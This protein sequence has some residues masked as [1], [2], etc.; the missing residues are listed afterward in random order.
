MKS[1]TASRPST[2]RSFT[3]C[4]TR[5]PAAAGLALP[6]LSSGSSKLSS[7]APGGT[8]R[9]MTLRRLRSN[10]GRQGRN[11]AAALAEG[12]RSEGGAANASA[13]VAL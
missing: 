3:T 6:P 11:G 7:M 4:T 5:W 8:E 10:R 13:S 2:T 9:S 12:V 1:L